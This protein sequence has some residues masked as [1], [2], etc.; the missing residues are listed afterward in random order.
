MR[1][2]LRLFSREKNSGI[3]S[4][5]L[6]ISYFILFL[7]LLSL[8]YFQ[9]GS[10]AHELAEKNWE[11][12]SSEV[13]FCGAT[14]LTETLGNFWRDDR[15]EGASNLTFRSFLSANFHRPILER[16][17]SIFNFPE[18]SKIVFFPRIS[19]P[20]RGVLIKIFKNE[21]ALSDFINNKKADRPPYFGNG[22]IGF[23]ELVFDREKK[24]IMVDRTYALNQRNQIIDLKRGQF[25][26]ETDFWKE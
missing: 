6:K 9:R 5:L 19:F 23:I 7:L 14:Y 10:I 15:I 18:P 8:F 2:I 17:I 21:K 16:W 26:Q 11:K 3:A 22:E 25:S 4:L 1:V 24:K 13:I 12:S 20:I